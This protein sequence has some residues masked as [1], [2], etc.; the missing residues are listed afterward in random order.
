MMTEDG[1]QVSQQM[2]GDNGKHKYAV[3]VQESTREKKR[4]TIQQEVI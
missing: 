3:L 4:K 2:M 1:K